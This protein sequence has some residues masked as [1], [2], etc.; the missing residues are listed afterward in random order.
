[1]NSRPPKKGMGGGMGVSPMSGTHAPPVPPGGA[2]LLEV[3]LSM[4]ILVG[5]SAG[6][7]LA[8][9]ASFRAAETIELEAAA[10]DLAVSLC[11][12]IQLGLVPPAADGPREF[13]QP[14]GWTW[15]IVTPEAAPPADSPAQAA[16]F[17]LLEIVITN[18]A[19]KYTYRLV[20]VVAE[21]PA[22]GRDVPVA[23]VGASR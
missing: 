3:V 13:D 18:T 9:H 7:M 21:P 6:M 10:A 2:I 20:H 12:R 14:A 16:G 1:M 5:V 11:S 17:R 15:Q 22:E 4:A 19:R 23:S 8:T